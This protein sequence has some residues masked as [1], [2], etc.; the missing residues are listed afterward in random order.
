ME[1][2]KWLDDL[3]QGSEDIC[4]LAWRLQRLGDSFYHTG[5]EYMGTKLHK[6]AEKLLES[7]DKVHKA[8]GLVTSEM[9]KT[10]QNN[11]ATVFKAVLAGIQVS[12]RDTKQ[13][14]KGDN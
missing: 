11:T 8:T 4:N 14:E 1:K 9:L 10:A 6:I 2:T 12:K 5:N 13:L 3:H 7:S